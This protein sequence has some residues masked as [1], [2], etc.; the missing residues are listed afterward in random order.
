ML[1]LERGAIFLPFALTK[2]NQKNPVNSVGDTKCRDIFWSL[3]LLKPLLIFPCKFF[4]VSHQGTRKSTKRPHNLLCWILLLT[5]DLSFFSTS[6]TH[7]ILLKLS[8]TFRVGRQFYVAPLWAPSISQNTLEI[9]EVKWW[10]CCD[11]EHNE[12][13]YACS[14]RGVK[15]HACL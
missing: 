1:S 7:T 10:P 6:S 11:P 8:A 5:T 2:K 9:D 13:H 3:S 12:N 15:T 4:A 14:S